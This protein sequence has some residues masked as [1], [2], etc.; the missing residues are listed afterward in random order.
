M[1]RGTTATP[2]SAAKKR[3]TGGDNYNTAPSKKAAT[4][5][6][7]QKFEPVFAMDEPEDD[8][9]VRISE[10]IAFSMKDGLIGRT[11]TSEYGSSSTSL[12]FEMVLQG[13]MDSFCVDFGGGWPLM[14]RTRLRGTNCL[15]A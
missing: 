7:H 6:P 3:K 8:L 4:N 15:L 10:D 13:N 1:I 11:I 9:E 2:I 12:Y 14:Y 5:T